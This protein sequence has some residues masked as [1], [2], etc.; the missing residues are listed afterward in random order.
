M[1]FNVE[2]D[3]GY[4]IVGYIV[5]DNFSQIATFRIV[6]NNQVLLQMQT[7]HLK[8]ALVSAGR[9]ETGQCGFLIDSNLL[10][11]LQHL[12]ELEIIDVESGLLIYRRNKDFFINKRI[13]RIDTHLKPLTFF[14]QSLKP[15]FQ[16]HAY[17]IERYGRETINQLF[18]LNGIRS[19]YMAGRIF[20]RNHEHY[21]NSEISTI[22]LLQNPYIEVAERLLIL[23]IVSKSD[24]RILNERD[25]LFFDEA[26][27]FAHSLDFKDV[28]T[29][30][31]CLNSM[32]KT[33]AALLSNPVVRQLTTSAPDEMPQGMSLASALDVLSACTVVGIRSQSENACEML[34]HLMGLSPNLIN[35]P[36]ST[37]PAIRFGAILQETGAIDA[38]IEK[39]LELYR[40]VAHAV[41]A[42]EAI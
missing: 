5:P 41:A 18:L 42:T 32:S 3:L 10:P 34:A 15:F 17:S 40:T 7:T 24:R 12:T 25:R 37:D 28:K 30:R 27:R 21:L 14:D 19:S 22:V 31:K 35:L 1:L 16:H 20:F 23:N 39:D 29:L 9:H 36:R 6:S 13:L 8:S 26:I 2:E 4:Q 38:I 11:N 33:V